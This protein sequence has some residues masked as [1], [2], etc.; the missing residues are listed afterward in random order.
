M[1][2]LGS[3]LLGA[4]CGDDN[5]S[6]QTLAVNAEDTAEAVA[7]N[8]V[9]PFQKLAVC[10]VSTGQTTGAGATGPSGTG[11]SASG[12]IATSQSATTGASLGGLVCAKNGKTY[13]DI[14]AAGGPANVAH[15]GGCADFVCNGAVCAAGF[16]CQSPSGPGTPD[17]CV[18]D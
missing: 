1:A 16:T 9:V 4:G 14:C 11:P 10:P 6:G 3:A 15:T 5:S 12:S 2:G 18:A 7:A 8:P 13:S 17:R